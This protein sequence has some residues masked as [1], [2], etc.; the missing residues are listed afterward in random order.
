MSPNLENATKAA[1]C[2]AL[3]CDDLR[4]LAVTDNLILSDVVMAE[5]EIAVAQRI[6]LQRLVDNLAQME[7]KP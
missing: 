6:R 4:A 5:L 2:A 3:L 1:Q 7:E